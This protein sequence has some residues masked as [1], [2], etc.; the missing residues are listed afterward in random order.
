A[1][2]ARAEQRRHRGVGSRPGAGPGHR[3][4]ARR[5]PAHV[6][7]TVRHP[8][9]R[10]HGSLTAGGPHCGGLNRWRTRP[11]MNLF[12]RISTSRLI[13]LLGT[14]AAVVL[15]GGIAVARSSAP[16]KPPA[17]PLAVALHDAVTA[18]PPAGI[19]ARI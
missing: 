6:S 7:R 3:R 9:S 18:K 8:S 2:L 10:S 17:K 13:V 14:V 15:V 19:Y 5:Q 16:A 12:R 1:V 11:T 4:A